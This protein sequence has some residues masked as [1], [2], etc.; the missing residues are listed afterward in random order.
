MLPSAIQHGLTEALSS[1]AG[2][3]PYGPA[4]LGGAFLLARLRD[5][6]AQL[7]AILN[8]LPRISTSNRSG[9]LISRKT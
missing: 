6:S 9:T 7:R 5:N 1:P 2:C 8:K 4:F 3:S